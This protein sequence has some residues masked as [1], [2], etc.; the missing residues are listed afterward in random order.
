MC[1]RYWLI[2]TGFVSN[3][4]VH[5]LFRPRVSELKTEPLF[6]HYIEP[7]YNIVTKLTYTIDVP[8]LPRAWFFGS[9]TFNLIAPERIKVNTQFKE[10]N[11][12]ITELTF[13]ESTPNFKEITT[14]S[15]RLKT[16]ER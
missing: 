11:P 6:I 3:E 8:L 1:R 10:D 4:I 9:S 16:D 13:N 14:F 2:I 5:P 15:G 12:Y 7:D